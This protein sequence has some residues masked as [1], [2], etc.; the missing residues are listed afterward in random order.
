M[1]SAAG[2]NKKPRKMISEGKFAFYLLLPIIILSCALI[3]YPFLYSIYLSF[4]EL[5]LMR[6]QLG[7]E[8]VGLQ[9]F[10]EVLR[11]PEFWTSLRTTSYFSLASVLG[12]FFIGLTAALLLNNKFAGRG[13]ARSFLLIPWAI[14]T[15]II[16]MIWKIMLNPNTGVM[17]AAL[18]QL[19]VIDQYIGWLADPKWAFIMLTLAQIWKSFPF[20]TLL[21]LAALQS[22]SKDLYEAARVD[23]SGRWSGFRHVTWPLLMPTTLVLLVLQTIGAFQAFDLI[24]GLTKGG[25]AN[26]TQVIGLHIYTQSFQFTKFG[27]GAA[28]S[29]IITFFI[30]L[31]VILYMKLLREKDLY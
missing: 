15:I 28:S 13:V 23:G 5:N 18:S 6:P 1:S 26:A 21:Y 27:Y 3:L 29:Y 11:N 19:G 25:P 12:T 31:L 2:A 22:I 4:V 8:F 7:P 17:N 9:F 10:G 30:L 16:G 20:V 24:Y 14:P